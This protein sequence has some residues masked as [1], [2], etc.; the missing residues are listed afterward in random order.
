MLLV[1]S[2]LCSIDQSWPHACHYHQLLQEVLMIHSL[3]LGMLPPRNNWRSVSKEEWRRRR[4]GVGWA[5][6]TMALYPS[7]KK[8]RVSSK[9]NGTSSAWHLAQI[10]A[11]P[12]ASLSQRNRSSLPSSELF[13]SNN[14]SAEVARGPCNGWASVRLAETR[15]RWADCWQV[16]LIS[17]SQARSLR[18]SSSIPW[19]A[20][21]WPDSPCVC[22]V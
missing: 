1:D 3:F 22:V 8:R 15:K 16:Y 21:K 5:A 7:S 19:G 17:L 13:C 2:S 6:Q 14:R 10:F 12:P 20:R 9:E 4:R 18:H 11:P